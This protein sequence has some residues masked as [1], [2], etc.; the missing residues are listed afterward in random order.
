MKLYKMIFFITK[1]TIFF[2]TVICLCTTS[3]AQEVKPVKRIF[4]LG[5][6]LTE[7]YGVSKSESYPELLDGLLNKSHPGV[8]KVISAGISGSTTSSGLNRLKWILKTNPYMVVLTLG[9]ND[10]MRGIPVATIY[11]NLEQMLKLLADNKIKCA[12]T[13]IKAPPNY[14]VEYTR[15]FE[16]IWV[17]LNKKYKP[18]W[19]PFLLEGVAGEKELNIEDGIHPNSK[20]HKK[21]A[22]NLYQVLKG[23]L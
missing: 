10:G 3:F 7:G 14:G 2:V 23:S 12:L 19:F 22:E 20:G 1:W 16:K 8:Y 5:D 17:E 13:G 11:N 15:S 6:S 4:I 21:M 18:I 9:S